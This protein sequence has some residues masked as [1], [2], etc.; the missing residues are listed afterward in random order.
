MES[1]GIELQ[2]L[3]GKKGEAES[4]AQEE[5]IRAEEGKGEDGNQIVTEDKGIGRS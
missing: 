5:K 1:E 4:T 3:S 2:E